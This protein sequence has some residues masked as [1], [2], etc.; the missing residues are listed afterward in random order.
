MANYRNL[1][2][3]SMVFLASCSWFD[4]PTVSSKNN[5][6][7]SNL[8]AVSYNSLPGWQNDDLRYALKSFRQSCKSKSFKDGTRYYAKIRPN[9]ELIAE[10][11]AFLPSESADNATV[12]A[13]FESHFQPYQIRADGGKNTGVFTGYYS[14][15]IMASRYKSAKYNEPIMMAPSNMNSYKGVDRKTIVSKQ[16]GTPLYWANKVDVQNLQIQGSG[17]LKL[18]DGTVAKMN[19]GAHN[20]MTFKSI[21][22][23]LKQK[24]IRPDEGY[25]S[26]AVWKHLKAHPALADEVIDKN[27]RYIYFVEA[28]DHDAIGK[29]GVPLT[30]IRSIAVDDSIYTLGLPMYVD[31]QLSNGQKFQRLMVGQDRG[32]AITGWIRADIFFGFGEEAE[33]FASPQYNEG[34]MFI[35]MP[36]PYEPVDKSMFN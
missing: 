21:G 35:L 11:C 27:P 22:E 3:A 28:K 6:V 14:P 34:R 24:G 12:R 2:M 29:L 7:T 19:F 18:D 5:Q 30:K 26:A 20:D 9:A 4:Q 17:L 1:L 31:T 23:Q 16:I 15:T 32:S 25:K 33:A 13:W 10:K 8:T 36:K